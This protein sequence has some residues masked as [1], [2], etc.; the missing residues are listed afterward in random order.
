[1]TKLGGGGHPERIT[2]IK[3]F[4]DRYNWEEINYWS[5]KNDWKKAKKNNL[6]IALDVL[7]NENEKI[8]PGVVL[9]HYSNYKKHINFSIIP[10]VETSHYIAL[11]NYLHY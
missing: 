3:P 4:T 1:M 8:Y 9:K 11:K 10:N 6:V 2:K 5:G 7:Y